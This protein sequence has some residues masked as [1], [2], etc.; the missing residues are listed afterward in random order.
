MTM[1]YKIPDIKG[2]KID[3]AIETLKEKKIKYNEDY[4]YKVTFFKKRNTVIKTDPEIGKKVTENKEIDIYVSRFMLAPIF[5]ILLLILIPS[6]IYLNGGFSRFKFDENSSPHI[7]TTKTGWQK[8]NTVYVSKEAILDNIKYYEYCIREDNKVSACTWQR[9]DTKNTRIDTTGIWNVWFRAVGEK[10]TSKV[11]NMVT[12]YIDNDAPVIKDINYTLNDK[13]IIINFDLNDPTS[14]ISLVEYSIDNSE[15][16][17]VDD[18]TNGIEIPDLTDGKHVICVRVHDEANNIVETCININIPE[19]KGAEEIDNTSSPIINLDKIPLTIEYLDDYEL[20]SYVWY[21]N[22]DGKTTCTVNGNIYTN[23]NQLGLGENTIKCSAEDI[24]GKTAKVEK[25]IMVKYQSEDPA[26]QEADSG[27][28]WLTLYY[29]N[30]SIEWEYEIRNPKHVRTY[31]EGWQPYTGPVLVHVDDV[32]NVFIRYDLNGKSVI[33]APEGRNLVSIEPDKRAVK[34]GSKS[35]VTIYYA[36]GATQKLYK[37][38]NGP[39]QPYN[40]PFEVGPESYIYA[41]VV[42]RTPVYDNEGNLVVNKVSTDLDSMYISEYIPYDGTGGGAPIDDPDHPGGGSGGGS[43]NPGDPTGGGSGTDE[44]DPENPG[45]GSGHG[46]TPTNGPAGPGYYSEPEDDVNHEQIGGPT[47]SAYPSSILVDKVKV[48]ISTEYPARKIMYSIDNS[49]YEEYTEPL[50]IDENCVIKA[51]YVRDEDGL[52]S[53]ISYNRIYSVKHDKLPYVYISAD[54]DTLTSAQDK[55]TITIKSKD[56]DKVEY[57][58]DGILYV[59]YTKPFDVTE[60]CTIYARATN[61]YGETYEK[62][63]VNLKTAPRKKVSLYVSITG[64]PDNSFSQKV[65]EIEVTIN[66]DSKAV[67]KYYSLGDEGELIPYTGPFKINKNT[68]VRAYATAPNAIGSATKMF[69]YTNQGIADPVI[70]VEPTTAAQQAKVT[71]TYDQNATITQYRYGGMGWKDYEGSFYVTRN[72][73][74]YAR[75]YNADNV[76]SEAEYR[77]NNIVPIPSYRTL[78]K[79]DYIIIYLNYPEDS[80][81]SLREYRWKKDGEWKT[82]DTKGILLIKPETDVKKDENEGYRVLDENNKEVLFT[83]HYYILDTGVSEISENLFMRWNSGEA[84]GPTFMTSTN[85]IAATVD[86]GI[87]YRDND[88]RK[89]Y[90]IVNSSGPSEWMDYEGTLTVAEPGTTIYAKSV[91]PTGQWS[92]VSNITINN[93]DNVDPTIDITGEFNKPVDDVL[94]KV[95][96]ADN[97]KLQLAA[98]A[99]GAKEISDFWTS[100]NYEDPDEELN[101]TI[102]E[103]GYYSFYAM[104]AVGRESIKIIK[105]ENIGNDPRISID[106]TEWTT[107]KKVTIDYR[108]GFTNQYSLDLGATWKTYSAPITLNDQAIVIA[109]S[110][111]GNKVVG[112]RTFTVNNIDNTTPTVEITLD[113]EVLLNSDHPLPTKYYVNNKLSKGEVICKDE[114]NRELTN[115]STLGTGEHKVTCTVTTGA[116]KKASATKEF[117]IVRN[118]YSVDFNCTQAVQEW[119]APVNGLYR[120]TT[121][122]AQGGSTENAQG[123]KGGFASGEISLYEGNKFYIYVGCAGTDNTPGYNGGGS[124]NAQGA[125][126]GGATHIATTDLGELFNYENNKDDVVMVAG[127]GGGAGYKD[128]GA[129]GNKATPGLG[130]HGSAPTPGTLTEGGKG[131]DNATDGTFGRGGSITSEYT[132]HLAGAGGAGYYGGGAGGFGSPLNASEDG[133]GGAGGSNYVSTRFTNVKEDTGVRF[134]DGYAKITLLDQYEKETPTLKLDATHV[135]I[136]TEMTDV[137]NSLDYNG[138]G[139][140]TVESSDP[141]V[142]TVELDDNDNIVMHPG[143]KV[144]DATITVKSSKAVIY[145]A[146]ETSFTVNNKIS[147]FFK[148]ELDKSK[149]KTN[150]NVYNYR[151]VGPGTIT[152]TVTGANGGTATLTE[153]TSTVDAN[154]NRLSSGTLSIRATGYGEL[155]VKLEITG[156]ANYRSKT[157]IKKYTFTDPTVV[158]SSN[159]TAFQ[160]ALTEWGTISKAGN[161]Q[162]WYGTNSKTD[163]KIID[164][165]KGD[166]VIVETVNTNEWTGYYYQYKDPETGKYVIP[167]YK[168]TELDFDMTSSDSDDDAI[169]AMIRF[170]PQGVNTTTGANNGKF[171]GYI[172]LM[173]N[174]ANSG[175]NGYGNGG[176]SGYNNGYSNGIW[177]SNGISEF[178]SAC[179]SWSGTGSCSKLA[180]NRYYW[181]TRNRWQHYKFIADGSSLKVYRWDYHA[182]GVYTI[183]S[184]STLLYSASNSTYAT[185]TYGF[186]TESQAYAQFKN[187]KAVTRD[188]DGYKITQYDL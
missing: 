153:N 177:S 187:F 99:K 131:G 70:E 145:K 5:L 160:T 154:G 14:G 2:M 72:T 88:V 130:L 142:V 106:S 78:D 36:E 116:G 85:D 120:F 87:I 48:T 62:Y 134:D 73:T 30:N 97:N 57:S 39:W 12:V 3:K 158:S 156:D 42:V 174:H 175:T 84:S 32:R 58:L 168:Y 179:S 186:W 53:L 1:R 61:K 118:L 71:I 141:E 27:W 149:S 40:E 91:S 24:N 60:T 150:L 102:R 184:G 146:G 11:S 76:E 4:K 80:D 104:D 122:G 108:T 21:P 89:L 103:N 111:Q 22:K 152:S 23:T 77:I 69:D 31:K 55:S 7:A 121:Y 8:D 126:G 49:A 17:K 35:K 115:T 135:D 109:R 68:T 172:L 20:P 124:E 113:D 46:G 67:E 81:A 34:K 98:W 166:Y 15:Y 29:P 114:K 170:N 127:A 173:D 50:I 129:G 54:P 79:G 100:G 13:N 63:I 181:W 176:S 52:R 33:K 164:Y 159:D 41:K 148:L 178:S 86:V 139:E 112:S 110:L 101:L 136:D 74:I 140:L 16:K 162:N 82:Y 123:G 96:F 165:S 28:I 188:I 119:T 83:D 75:S 25:T 171:T 26:G 38:D 90:R 125:S 183:G 117:R 133:F 163:T 92:D 107:S 56:A 59:P 138:D 64:S 144:G 9:T 47:I 51:Y 185:G 10:D 143:T 45:G 43:G 157:F 147:P 137:I 105:I 44:D 128:G 37:V 167:Q 182:N 95:K 6:L 151:Y 94:L 93:I 65:D 66:Y 180:I 161:N 132:D 19:V 18:Y 155:T 169:G